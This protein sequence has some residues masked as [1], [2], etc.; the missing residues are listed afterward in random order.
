MPQNLS[1]SYQKLR[2]AENSRQNTPVKSRT[3]KAFGK[4]PST[5]SPTGE[6]VKPLCAKHFIARE[7][8]YGLA[9]VSKMYLL[10]SCITWY[11]TIFTIGFHSLHVE[12]LFNIAMVLST[13]L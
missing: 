11:K 13:G 3:K 8:E 1:D 7:K 2:S 4:R 5:A 6:P 10:Y 9:Q 12:K